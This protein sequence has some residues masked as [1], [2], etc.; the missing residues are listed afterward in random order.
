MR[1]PATKKPY[2]VDQLFDL[3]NEPIIALVNKESGEQNSGWVVAEFPYEDEESKKNSIQDAEFI[4][5]ACNVYQPMIELLENIEST[6]TDKLTA[7]KIRDFLNINK[8]WS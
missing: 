7:K 1:H 8:L 5:E 2:F 6:T 3:E 4:A